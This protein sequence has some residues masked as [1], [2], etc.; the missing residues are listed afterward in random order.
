M[1]LTGKTIAVLGGTGAEG[2]GLAFRWAHAGLSVVIGSR[3]GA[4]AAATAVELNTTLLGQGSKPIVGLDND[5]VAAR[6]DIVVL[7][8]PYAAQQA[9]ALA[10]K[11]HLAGKVLID[12]TVPLV[13]PKVDRVQLPGGRSAVEQLAEKLGPETHVVAAFQ[14]VGAHH[15][16]DLA[17]SIDCD[18]LVCGDSKAARDVAIALAA[19]AGLDGIHAGPLANAAAVEAMTSVLIAI[20]KAYKAKASGLRITGLPPR[21]PGGAA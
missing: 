2:S 3:D 12:V 4:R 14:N 13:P 11:Q 20:N 19:A 9:T 1:P 5:S 8:V 6:G 16:K 10:V 21:T 7:A 15:L 18:V 17:H